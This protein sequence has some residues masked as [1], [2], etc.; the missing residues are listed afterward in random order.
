[1]LALPHME[2]QVRLQAWM[3]A[4][5]QG[6]CH[7]VMSQ[8]LLTLGAILATW[9]GT[10]HYPADRQGEVALRWHAR[11][12]EGLF[13]CSVP[14]DTSDT[15]DKFFEGN[16]LLWMMN[17]TLRSKLDAVSFFFAKWRSISVELCKWSLQEWARMKPSHS[18]KDA[19]LT[20][21]M[22]YSRFAE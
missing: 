3:W 2:T 19:Y 15:A 11:K 17:K 21:Q 20:R 4:V 10:P 22:A 13:L 6:W 1:M 18:A 8:W 16:I 14:W 7:W 12:T 9:A 5:I